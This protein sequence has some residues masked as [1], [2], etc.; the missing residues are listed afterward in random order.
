MASSNEL[1]QVAFPVEWVN[2]DTTESEYKT[3]VDLGF[4]VRTRFDEDPLYDS[5]SDMDLDVSE[6]D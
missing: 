4:D 2:E 3:D 5:Y 6:E 1:S